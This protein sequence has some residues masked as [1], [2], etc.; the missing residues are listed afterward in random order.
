MRMRSWI[1]ERAFAAMVDQ[2]E[3]WAKGQCSPK[4]FLIGRF[5]RS[6]ILRNNELWKKLLQGSEKNLDSDGL[7]ADNGHNSSVL[8]KDI[9]QN[10]YLDCI[11]CIVPLK[12][13]SSVQD[14][15]S[16]CRFCLQILETLSYPLLP[17][18]FL[19][20]DQELLQFVLMHRWLHS[21]RMM[22]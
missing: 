7:K 5:D 22:V 14:A 4:S 3:P 20:W 15:Y 17:F 9:L 19:L 1:R 18:W 21:L 12:R 6:S 10:G 8:L 11:I 16:E 13:R 2:F